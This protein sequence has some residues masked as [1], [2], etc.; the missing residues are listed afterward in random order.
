M[1]WTRRTSCYF[2]GIEPAIS[3]GPG[4]AMVSLGAGPAYY[5]ASLNSG[6]GY[7]FT[8]DPGE[9]EMMRKKAI[10]RMIEHYSRR[11]GAADRD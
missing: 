3:F 10:P 11:K 9:P 7:Q 4:G 1:T 5:S 6:F 2:G 8:F